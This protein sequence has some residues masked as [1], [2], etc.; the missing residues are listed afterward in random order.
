M[1]RFLGT[2][3]AHGENKADESEF[4]KFFEL[5]GVDKEWQK[6][7][8]DN[9]GMKMI[10]GRNG[11]EW[12]HTLKTMDDATLRVN[13]VVL[14]KECDIKT[15]DGRDAK[16]TFT[17]KDGKFQGSTKLDGIDDTFVS[18][19]ELEGDNKLT[20][21]FCLPTKNFDGPTMNFTEA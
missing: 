1:D 7:M 19:Y 16:I 21:T 17:F 5:A 18:I 4:A 12:T 2:W 10:I 15:M 14:D 11:D 6:K 13:T 8:K 3:I 20:C 9:R